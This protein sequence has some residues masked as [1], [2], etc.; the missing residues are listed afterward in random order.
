METKC[1]T[2]K[3]QSHS[4]CVARTLSGVKT[5]ASHVICL[6][7]RRNGTTKVA[8]GEEEDVE[9]KKKKRIPTQ[10]LLRKS[11]IP[12]ASKSHL[13]ILIESRSYAKQLVATLLKTRKTKE[14]KNTKII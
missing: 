6:C 14:K 4:S 2:F 7:S 10:C 9:G 3:A 11:S 1:T 13:T 8:K 5:K 12:F